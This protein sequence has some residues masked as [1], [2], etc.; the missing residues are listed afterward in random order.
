MEKFCGELRQLK[1][2]ADEPLIFEISKKCKKRFVMNALN[3]FLHY[4]NLFLHGHKGSDNIK[5]VTCSFSYCFIF[6]FQRITLAYSMP[7]SLTVEKLYQS[8]ITDKCFM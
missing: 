2:L 3:V 6:C 4:L 5:L 7:V 8:T 1:K